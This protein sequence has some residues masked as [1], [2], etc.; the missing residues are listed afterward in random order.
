MICWR[1]RYLHVLLKV[2]IKKNREV[3][4]SSDETD[5]DIPSE[6]K[7][8]YTRLSGCTVLVDRWSRKGGGSQRRGAIDER[9]PSNVSCHL[10]VGEEPPQNRLL[11]E[12]QLG[13]R[14]HTRRVP[15]GDLRGV[16][17]RSSGFSP[18]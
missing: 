15:N 16:P 12:L 2:K 6:D 3:L 14:P 13:R 10:P 7:S 4:H 1:K 8:E 18:G 5:N 9:D 17:D 11:E